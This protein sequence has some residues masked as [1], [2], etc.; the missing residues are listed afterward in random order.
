LHDRLRKEIERILVPLLRGRSDHICIIDPPGHPN[1]GDSAILLGEL[2]FIAQ[3]FPR[4]R[5]SFYDV[6]SYSPAADRYIEQATILLIHGGGN[7]GDIWPRHHQLRM[8]IIETFPHKTIIQMPQ[9]IHFDS[10][11]ELMSTAAAIK[12]HPDFTLLVRDKRSFDFAVKSFECTVHLVPD[13]A[14]AMKPIT[15]HSPTVDYFCLLREDKEAAVDHGAILNALRER[16]GTIEDRDWLDE[17]QTFTARLD[18]RL[19]WRTKANPASTA[20]LRPR[21]MRLRQHHA[22]RRLSYGIELLSRGRTVVTDRL[23]A[24]ILSCLLRIPNLTFDSYDGKISAFYET[25][26]H[27]DA[28]AGLVASPADL[29]AAKVT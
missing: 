18:Q 28:N 8:R 5:L 15:R 23:H 26:T 6:E 13:M 24:H 3:H 1:V 22:L 7:F 16:G 19:G 12:A 11:H 9:S 10:D 14:F 4:A 25:W 21:M 29:L 20:F 2:D 17:Q 27:E